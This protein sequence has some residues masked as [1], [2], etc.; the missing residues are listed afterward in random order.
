MY[1]YESE[2]FMNNLFEGV[3]IVD[4]KRKIVFWNKGS[5]NITG[6]KAE[7]VV[8][9]HC[10]QNIL[11]HVDETGKRLCFEG[12]PLQRTLRTG[13]T[14]E[15]QVFLSHKSGY[16]IPVSV[17]TLPLFDDDGNI[18]AAV[19]V[20]TDS[21]YKEDKYLENLELKNAAQY[22][23][24]TQVYNRKFL[25]FKLKNLL[26]ES[27]QFDREFGVLF[28]DIDHFKNINDQYGHNI[29]D[30][31]LKIVS[32][33]IR[34]GLRPDDTFGR[35]GGEEFVAIIDTD[36]LDTLHDIAERIRM[37][38]FNSNY[39]TDNSEIIR[40]SISIGGTIYEKGESSSALIKRADKN[41]YS[42]KNSGRN[43]VTVN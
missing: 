35:W 31:I 2:K 26:S 32:T 30:E 8:N 3:Y 11:N 41:M 20:F 38:V 29:G 7:D 22:D 42:S 17:K 6:Y 14:V 13:E 24:L 25:D 28:I 16:R 5:E 19:E 27:T 43:R 18:V 9:A 40:A 36:S 23:E 4:K 34:N 10:Y 1:K 21:R 37:L 15:N 12:C 39:K 33:T